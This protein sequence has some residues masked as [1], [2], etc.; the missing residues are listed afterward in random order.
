MTNFNTMT[1]AALVEALIR[2]HLR[3]R[4]RDDR[5]LLAA[6][7]ERLINDVRRDTK[8]TLTARPTKTTND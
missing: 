2:L 5:D 8:V 1:T 6:A 4:D 3:T 7:C